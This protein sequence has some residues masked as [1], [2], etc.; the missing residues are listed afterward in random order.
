MEQKFNVNENIFIIV[1]SSIAG[2]MVILKGKITCIKQT[3]DTFLQ[4]EIVE[5]VRNIVYRVEYCLNDHY[6]TIDFQEIEIYKTQKEAEDYL[7][8]KVIKMARTYI[9]EGK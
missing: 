5:T 3:V 7:I 4:N 1:Y 9:G 2:G 8:A 6:Q